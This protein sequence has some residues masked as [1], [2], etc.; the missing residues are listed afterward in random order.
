MHNYAEAKELYSRGAA[1]GEEHC[2]YYLGQMY[3][4]GLGVSKDYGKAESWYIKA[5]EHGYPSALYNIGL[6]HL[7][8]GAGMSRDCNT[9]RSWFEKAAAH[10]SSAAQTWLAANQSCQ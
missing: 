6:L 9:A 10:G 3:E 7:G 2:M 5:A 1:K 8:G 4:H